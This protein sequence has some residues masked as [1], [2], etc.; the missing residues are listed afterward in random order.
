MK[1]HD[2]LSKK[3]AMNLHATM[4]VERVEDSDGQQLRHLGYV[5]IIKLIFHGIYLSKAKYYNR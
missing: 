5:V 1:R 2:R 4:H 3:S